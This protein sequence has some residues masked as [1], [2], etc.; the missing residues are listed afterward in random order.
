MVRTKLSARRGQ[1]IQLATIPDC[2]AVPKPLISMEAK[3][4]MLLSKKEMKRTINEVITLIDCHLSYAVDMERPDSKVEYIKVAN[5]ISRILSS[6]WFH[7]A[8]QKLYDLV[9]CGILESGIEFGY[10][11]TQN[12]KPR[13]E[14]ENLYPIRDRIRSELGYHISK[15]KEKVE[16]ADEEEEISEELVALKKTLGR[17]ME[18]EKPSLTP[19]AE[20]AKELLDNWEAF[21]TDC[22]Y[23]D[24]PPTTNSCCGSFTTWEEENQS[25]GVCGK[26]HD[27]C[28]SCGR[29]DKDGDGGM[30]WD[31]D[32]D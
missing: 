9:D 4:E 24:L 31:G 25:C 2:S 29:H 19:L 15:I 17:I 21:E 3:N 14:A 30:G 13:S 32:S 1:R 20:S 26:H 7:L 10:A 5:D 6:K 11:I 12:N 28:S 8:P 22:D 27:W 18:D 23:N 16:G